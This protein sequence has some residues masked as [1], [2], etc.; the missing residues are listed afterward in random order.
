MAKNN[1]NQKEKEVVVKTPEQTQAQTTQTAPAEQTVSKDN[2]QTPG[3]TKA[4]EKAQEQTAK[5]TDIARLAEVLGNKTDKLGK[6]MDKMSDQI[7]TGISNVIR[8]SIPAAAQ[9]AARAVLEEQAQAQ[10]APTAQAPQ[11]DASAPTAQEPEDLKIKVKNRSDGKPLDGKEDQADLEP[12][13]VTWRLQKG[14]W[15]RLISTIAGVGFLLQS[16][17]L[18]NAFSWAGIVAIVGLGIATLGLLADTIRLSIFPSKISQRN[19]GLLCGVG[20][21]LMIGGILIGLIGKIPQPANSANQT[22][23]AI[24]SEAPASSAPAVSS[25]A[26][27]AS[28]PAAT[29]S[30]FSLGKPANTK[31]VDSGVWNKPM[32]D[33]V[34]ITGEGIVYYVQSGKD[35]SKTLK[36]KVPEGAYLVLDAF[37]ISKTTKGEPESFTNGNIFVAAG[38]LDLDA[39]PINY[40]DGA[41]QC[42]GKEGLQDLLDNNIAVK[43]ARG[44]WD[45]KKNQWSY[46]HWAEDNIFIPKGFKYNSIVLTYETDTYPGRDTAPDMSN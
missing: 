1:E 40:V 28:T 11:A 15:L 45:T 6:K 35:G 18:I 43:F 42:I 29:A 25:A 10:S 9:A 46:N 36:G 20:L 44:N 4:N 26:P 24:V 37:T 12:K 8:E 39:N 31:D 41:A 21:V 14:F 38:P 22:P 34:M 32:K 16:N 7:V 17:W 30:S 5:S 27:A 2:K 23:A 19:T 3:A 33:A 13:K